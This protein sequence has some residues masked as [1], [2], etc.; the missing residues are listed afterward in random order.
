MPG[1][2]P[3]LTTESLCMSENAG[4]VFVALL[5]GIAAPWIWT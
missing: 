2:R 1:I 4:S 5:N 3:G